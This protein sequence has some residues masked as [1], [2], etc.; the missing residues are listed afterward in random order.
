M[1]IARLSPP[2]APDAKA[3]REGTPLFVVAGAC[4][5]SFAGV[6]AVMYAAMQPAA[7][8][9]AAAAVGSPGAPAAGGSGSAPEVDFWWVKPRADARRQLDK[10]TLPRNV[11]GPH[12]NT[13]GGSA[14]V[15]PRRGSRTRG[16]AAC[17]RAAG[18]PALLAPAESTR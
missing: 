18:L 2:A 9:G 13:P 17:C 15:R 3:G 11:S 5:S 8:A 4:P 1:R 10:G 12:K 14:A 7:A 16:L 6:Q